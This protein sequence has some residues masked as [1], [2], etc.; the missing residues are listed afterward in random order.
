MVVNIMTGDRSNFETFDLNNRNTVKF[1]N[2][3]P[4]LVKGKGSIILTNKITF[5][6][7]YYVEGLNITF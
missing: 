2:D 6:N 5:D 7:S 4:C 1:G 3:A